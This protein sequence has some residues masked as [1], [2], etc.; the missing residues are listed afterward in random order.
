MR[1]I[2][3]RLLDVIEAPALDRAAERKMLVAQEDEERGRGAAEAAGGGFLFG[4]QAIDHRLGAQ[5]QGA[6]KGVIHRHVP[7][8]SNR[9]LQSP[10][11]RVESCAPLPPVAGG[12]K[13]TGPDAGKPWWNAS[14]ERPNVYSN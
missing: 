14:V 9:A 7:R 1:P 4:Q 2:Q 5:L 8:V 3:Q 12:N 10:V 13:G 6:G 11:E